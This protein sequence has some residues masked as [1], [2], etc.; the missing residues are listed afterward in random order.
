[1]CT[2]LFEIRH[3]LKKKKKK[4]GRV[5]FANLAENEFMKFPLGKSIRILTDHKEMRLVKADSSRLPVN[6]TVTEIRRC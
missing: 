6:E 4:E 2:F 5:W 3:T 1:M